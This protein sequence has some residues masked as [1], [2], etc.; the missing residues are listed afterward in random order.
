MAGRKSRRDPEAQ[1][2]KLS[3]SREEAD[4]A[5][6]ILSKLVNDG[7]EEGVDL[8]QLA[9]VVRNSGR[10]RLHFFAADVFGDPAWDII[11][12][13][14]C[15]QG[16]GEQLSITALGHS[17]G[18]AQS[19]VSR[20]VPLLIKENIVE[21]FHQEGDQRRVFLRLTRS[22]HAQTGLWLR[23]VGAQLALIWPR[24]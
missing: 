16:R 2:V 22:G 17:A 4:A 5:R 12:S 23:H 19:T 9:T 11:L 7:R 10:E 8:L 14:Y 1:A 3:L 15:A 20:W 13:L 6:S 21:R 18:H 24:P